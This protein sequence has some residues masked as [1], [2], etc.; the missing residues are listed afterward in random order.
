MLPVSCDESGCI[1]IDGGIASVLSD[2][3]PRAPKGLPREPLDPPELVEKD[4]SAI[5]P[6]ELPAAPISLPLVASADD[7]IS[8]EP[9]I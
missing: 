3:S 7:T 2:V 9:A 4:V 6:E 8:T 1:G 5:L